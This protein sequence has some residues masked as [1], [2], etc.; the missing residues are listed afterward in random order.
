M[1]QRVDSLADLLADDEGNFRPEI[2]DLINQP[3]PARRRPDAES[4]RWLLYGIG[5]FLLLMPIVLALSQEDKPKVQPDRGGERVFETERNTEEATNLKRAGSFY[6][7]GEGKHLPDEGAAAG[8][9]ASQ[10]S[11]LHFVSVS[12]LYHAR[13]EEDQPK[14]DANIESPA[15][16]SPPAA[17]PDALGRGKVFGYHVNLREG[18]SLNAAI[19]RQT[20]QGELFT[21]LSFSNGWYRLNLPDE[22]PAYIFGAYL[23][24]LDFSIAFHHVGV[25]DR[26][27]KILLASCPY[28][29]QYR[30]ILPDGSTQFIGKDHVR[31]ITK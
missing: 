15:D 9:I 24:P 12:P 23:L 17:A 6:Q 28:P 21:V 25:D 20:S 19:I 30:L 27:R 8:S 22:Q 4:I 29:E 16:P 5:L 10:N 26:Q 31:I 7:E 13:P 18:P 14:A 1:V 3:L 2:V 11:E